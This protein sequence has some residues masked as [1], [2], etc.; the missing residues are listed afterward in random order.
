M[1]IGLSSACFYPNL[2]N[3]N[4]INLIKNI[5]FNCAEVFLN[6]PR[7]FEQNYVNELAFKKNNINLKVNSIH[8]FSSFFEPYLFDSY[9]RRRDD[10]FEIFKKVCN[11]GKL[12]DAD[13]YTFH[14]MRDIDK[15]SLNMDFILDIYNKLIYTAADIGI[16]LAQENVSWC[17]SSDL[18]LL[19]CL[20]E[21]CKYP[22]YFTLDIKQAYKAGIEPEKYIDVMGERIINFHIND[23]N[24]EKLCLLPGKGDVD[25]KAIGEKLKSTGY[26]GCGIIEVY[27][28]NYTNYS[29]ILDSK[30]YLGKFL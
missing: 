1:E 18:Q 12:L 30:E 24:S 11:A 23:R 20:K 14:G 28:E 2:D 19:K 4:A 15:K 21:N 26:K 5:G 8:S 3:E 29:Q 13:C 9:K 17:I 27:S 22:L 6:S 7:E 25:I 16:K 10:M